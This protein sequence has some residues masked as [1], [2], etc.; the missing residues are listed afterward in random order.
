MN[1]RM[2]VLRVVLT[3]A[4]P[5]LAAF[6][7]GATYADDVTLTG[8][9]A[10]VTI[11][12]GNSLTLTFT[13]TNVSSDTVRTAGLGVGTGPF[14]GPDS[15]D[16]VLP[17]TVST[18]GCTVSGLTLSPGDSCTFTATYSTEDPSGETDTDFEVGGALAELNYCVV[19][20]SGLCTGVNGG[21]TLFGAIDTFDITV[22][23]PAPTPEPSSA[24]LLAAGLAA[25]L[26]LG[27]LRSRN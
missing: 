14:T 1:L 25:L 22:T 8:A 20:P 17:S 6:L 18:G 5:T 23:D 21:G 15:S 13:A 9:P 7:P 11:T 26:G 19:S 24:H 4:V 12:E 2:F 3:A 16:V 27:W 10:S